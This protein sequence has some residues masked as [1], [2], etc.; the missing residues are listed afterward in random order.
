MRLTRLPDWRA[1]LARY[2]DACAR[3]PYAPGTHDC[4]LFAAGAVAAQTGIDFARAFRGAYASVAE[5]EA[6]LGAGIAAHAASILPARPGVL[7]AVEG[8]VAVIAP[9]KGP[10][11]LGVVAG[12]HILVLR[13]RGLGRV[14]LADAARV[15]AV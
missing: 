2:L 4:A 13:P 6:L 10:E 15:L 11:V 3:L 14:G 7:A 8:D 9:P 1:R 12:A 5:G